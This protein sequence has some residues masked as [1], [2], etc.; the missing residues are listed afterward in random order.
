[1]KGIK[2]RSDVVAWTDEDGTQYI[3]RKENGVLEGEGIRIGKDNITYIGEFKNGIRIMMTAIIMWV[4]LQTIDE[5]AW[6][7]TIIATEE[8]RR[9]GI[10]ANGKME[11]GMGNVL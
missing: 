1:M 10:T 2:N 4:N 6:A 3:G 11:N 7:F 9:T 5:M 8:T